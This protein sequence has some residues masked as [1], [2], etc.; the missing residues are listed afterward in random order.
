MRTRFV[1]DNWKSTA[2]RRKHGVPFEEARSC[3]TDPWQV[4][5]YDP[6]HSHDETRELLIGHSSLGRLLIVS[7]TLRGFS[8][9]I[10]SARK[11]TR[12]EADTYAQGI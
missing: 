9:R 7:Y 10:I 4:A 5:F 3:F 6:D 8:V 11:V 1:W 12:T 2:N